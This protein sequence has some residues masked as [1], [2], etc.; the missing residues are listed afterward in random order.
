[1]PLNRR[2]P[3]RGF[4]NLFR[5]EY[6]VLNLD[7]VLRMAREE[8]SVDTVAWVKEGRIKGAKDG[9]KILGRGELQKALTIR[10]HKFSQS[11]KEKILAAGGVV[12][13]IT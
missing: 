10:A 13:E 8:H 4:V 11:A 7:D 1:M 5:K 9:V 12:E 3:K 2:L 6:D